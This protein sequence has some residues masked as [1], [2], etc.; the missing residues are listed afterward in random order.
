MVKRMMLL[1]VGVAALGLASCSL[2]IGE[3]SSSG[4]AVSSSDIAKFQKIFMSSYTAERGGTGGGA[5]AL[6]PFS[7]TITG[8]ATSNAR[9]TVPVYQL[10]NNSFLALSPS[11]LVNYPEPGQTTKFTVV[12]HDAPNSVYDVTV[13]T[14]YSPGD[15]RKNYVEEYYVRDIGKNGSGFF[16]TSTPDGQWTVDDPVVNWTSEGW[17]QNQKARVRQV[18]TFMDGTTRTETIVS[19]TDFAV[20]QLPKFAAFDVAGSLDF[21]QLFIP[22]TDTNAVFS[23]V[24]V[25]S[26]TPSTNPNFWFWQGSNS[27]TI[28]GIRYYT[29]FKTGGTYKTS[30]IAFEK[31]LST[32]NTQAVSMPQVWSTVFVGSQFDTLVESVL[33]QQVT[34]NLDSNGNPNLATG[35]STTNMQSRVVNI[36]GQK[37][38]YLTELNSDYVTLSGW[39][40]TTVY[41]PTG[42]AAEVVAADPSKFLYSRTGTASG[43]GTPLALSSTSGL[44]DLAGLYVSLV[45][46]AATVPVSNPLP[47]GPFLGSPNVMQFDGTDKGTQPTYVAG[48]YDLNPTGTIEAWVYVKQQMDTAGIVHKGANPD[49]SD[50]CYSLQFWGNQG[51]IALAL[52]GPGGGSYDLLTSTINLNTGRWYYLVATWDRTTTPNTMNLYINGNLN[53]SRTPTVSGAPQTNL[54]TNDLL[55]GSQ[56]PSVYNVAYGY[57][58]FNGAIYG[59]KV[60]PGTPPNAAT[61]LSFYNANKGLTASWPH[62]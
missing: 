56:L 2:P 39:D 1:A 26:V 36:T 19:Q 55:I 57:F 61:I 12:M 48:T 8:N 59:V 30:T 49:F 28:L 60:Y 18:L 22:G 7:Y 6:T 31:T 9:A 41:T 58:T 52:D 34:Y 62:P 14:T 23:S 11:T 3:S 5:R 25:Y 50:E 40:A 21:S 33:R 24:V 44:G 43:G 45:T 15:N 37:D 47:N 35:T 42:D 27:Q 51:Q 53:A 4:G 46:G 17:Q 29:E 20:T 10:V 32:L 54:S 13:T 16:D 38:F